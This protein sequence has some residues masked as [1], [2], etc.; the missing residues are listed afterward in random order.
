MNEPTDEQLERRARQLVG[1]WMST[2]SEGPALSEEDQK[3]ARKLMGRDNAERRAFHAGGR[4]KLKRSVVTAEYY[5]TPYDG[6]LGCW[7]IDVREN[8]ILR[9][10]REGLTR[11]ECITLIGKLQ[12]RGVTPKPVVTEWMKQQP[13][14]PKPDT[15]THRKSFVERFG[16]FAGVAG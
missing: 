5:E 13:P 7:R 8:G 11:I 6:C 2:R 16:D 1:E 12:A 10:S 14:E 9:N 15:L 4:F 3:I